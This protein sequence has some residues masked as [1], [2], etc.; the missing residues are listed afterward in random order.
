MGHLQNALALLL[1]TVAFGGGA[2][3]PTKRC[4]CRQD[5]TEKGRRLMID[6]GWTGTELI[7][8]RMV[9]HGDAGALNRWYRNHVKKTTAAAAT[10]PVTEDDRQFRDEARKE[11]TRISQGRQEKLIRA[12]PTPAPVVKPRSKKK[13][14]RRGKAAK[15]FRMHTNQLASVQVQKQQVLAIKDQ[16]LI[17]ACHALSEQRTTYEQSQQRFRKDDPNATCEPVPASSARICAVNA[18]KWAEEQ[19]VEQE[20]DFKELGVKMK[21]DGSIVNKRVN[22]G[23]LDD[24]YGKPGPAQ[25]IPKLLYDAAAAKS[26]ASQIAGSEAN[27]KK[28]ATEIAVAFQQK[29]GGAMPDVQTILRHLRQQH[30]AKGAAPVPAWCRYV[31]LSAIHLRLGAAM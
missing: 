12:A 19:C 24:G 31:H 2:G 10:K 23:R 25:K 17:R 14:P 29:E 26:N 13:Q 27:P 4:A 22:D 21:I 11:L 5:C 1:T 28:L 16:A 3:R 15:G 18:T 30:P 9:K 6:H 8:K 20:L 7:N